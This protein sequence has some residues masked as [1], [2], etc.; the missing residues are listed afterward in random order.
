MAQETSIPHVLSITQFVK[1]EPR[2][3]CPTIPTS[4]QIKGQNALKLIYAEHIEHFVIFGSLLSVNF[5]E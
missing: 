3:Q 4:T 2:V 5:G 1:G